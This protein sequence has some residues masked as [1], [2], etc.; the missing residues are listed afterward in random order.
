MPSLFLGEIAPIDLSDA[1]GMNLMNI[2]THKWDDKLVEICGGPE[3]KAKLGPEPVLGGSFI[4]KI[5]QWWVHRWGF[6][7]GMS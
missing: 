3:L 1:S 7:P 4:G 5:A 2:F 6:H